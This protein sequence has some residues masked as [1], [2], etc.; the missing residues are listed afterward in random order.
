MGSPGALIRRDAKLLSTVVR[1]GIATPI[2]RNHAPELWSANGRT[3]V[4][5]APAPR[6]APNT[7][8]R[9][10]AP[11]GGRGLHPGQGE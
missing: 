3:L 7:Y 9:L 11:R 6:E 2:A 10:K 4:R 8:V 5:H 1:Y